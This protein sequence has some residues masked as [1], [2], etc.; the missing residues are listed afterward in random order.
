M[1]NSEIEGFVQQIKLHCNPIENDPRADFSELLNRMPSVIHDDQFDG[2]FS[3]LSMTIL[4]YYQSK[5][6]I[7][8]F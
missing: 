5:D 2:L 4:L 1:A 7:K 3:Q 6:Y 8:T